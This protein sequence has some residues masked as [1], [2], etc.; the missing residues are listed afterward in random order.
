MAGELSIERVEG[1][2]RKWRSGRRGGSRAAPEEVRRAVL[3]LKRKRGWNFV[4]ERLGLG[5]STL[6]NWA[7]REKA[8]QEPRPHYSKPRRRGA[9][10]K[11]ERA[12]TR[13]SSISF[14]ELPVRPPEVRSLLQPGEAL[15]IEWQRQDGKRMKITGQALNPAQI[16]AWV[17]RFLDSSEQENTQ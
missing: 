1:L 13:P 9:S 14:L 3:E 4:S 10:P 16:E 7:R 15:S 2:V 5:S 12:V 11:G 17:S 8:N 6:W